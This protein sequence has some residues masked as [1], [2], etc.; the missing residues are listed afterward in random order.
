VR[1]RAGP[2]FERLGVIGLGLLGGS[3]ALAARERGLAR[4]VRGVDPALDEAG[5]IPVLGLEPA[6]RWADAVVLAV[7][8]SALEP[9]LAALARLLAPDAIVTDTASVKVPVARAVHRLLPHPER[10]IGAHPMAGGD[11]SGFRHA[12]PDLFEGAPCILTP[13]GSEPASVV[14]RVE[15]FWQGLGTFTVRQTPEEH[16]AL[17]ALLSHA[18]HA[19]AFAYAQ[20]LPDAAALR[21][22]GRGLR[23]FVR[24]ARS[25]PALWCEILLMNRQ[26]VTDEISRFEKHLGAIQDAL[27]RGDR[28]A[29]ER[30]L[31]EGRKAALQLEPEGETN[32]SMTKT[33]KA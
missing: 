16:D 18:P 13:A 11:A 12:R 3:V 5:P 7:P 21:L 33:G 6:A 15:Q 20:G 4:E 24:I 26:R 30:A 29:L 14:D 23:D 9:V 10:C 32:T 1:R 19:I 31:G 27:A 28:A 2:H 17:V 22:A 8:V 25:N